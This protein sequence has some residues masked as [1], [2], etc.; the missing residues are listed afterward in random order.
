MGKKKENVR[1]SEQRTR[2]AKKHATRCPECG[3]LILAE[4]CLECYLTSNNKKG[5]FFASAF[6][7]IYKENTR[8][9]RKKRVSS[10]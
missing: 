7:G 5:A 6:A 1:T 8:G 10:A 2:Y 9:S 3:R 4:Q